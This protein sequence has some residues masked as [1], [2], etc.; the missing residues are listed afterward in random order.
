MASGETVQIGDRVFND[1][2]VI[3]APPEAGYYSNYHKRRMVSFYSKQFGLLAFQIEHL[4]DDNKGPLWQLDGPI[5][6]GAMPTN[7]P[8]PS[9]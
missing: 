4:N 2:Y 9:P 5:G 1:V 8:D 6:V 7:T 3:A